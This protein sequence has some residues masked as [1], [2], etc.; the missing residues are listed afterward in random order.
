MGRLSATRMMRGCYRGRAGGARSP[1]APTPRRSTAVRP[2]VLPHRSRE[3]ERA[4]QVAAKFAGPGEI[5]ELRPVATAA[6]A[7]QTSREGHRQPS[8]FRPAQGDRDRP[9]LR[10]AVLGGKDPSRSPSG[11]VSRGVT[12]LVPALNSTRRFVIP[13]GPMP[14]SQPASGPSSSR[15]TTVVAPGDVTAPDEVAWNIASRSAMTPVVRT[16]PVADE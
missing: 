1:T 4:E 11:L 2:A 14:L 10:P 16:R 9:S 8:G 5:V 3:P 7:G 13:L 6:R 12:T 15:P